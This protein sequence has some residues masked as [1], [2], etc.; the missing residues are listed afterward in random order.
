MRRKEFTLERLAYHAEIS[1]ERR[2]HPKLLWP[3]V[4]IRILLLCAHVE[5]RKLGPD[6]RAHI[7]GNS[8]GPESRVLS[9]VSL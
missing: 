3:Q 1:T 2:Q 7:R 5:V 8:T 4:L 6:V 9:R